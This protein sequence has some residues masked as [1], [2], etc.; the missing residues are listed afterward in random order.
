VNP[1]ST[2][3]LL[4]AATPLLWSRSHLASTRLASLNGPRRTRS[5]NPVLTRAAL[6]ASSGL[7]AAV[8]AGWPL[9]PIIGPAVATGV[10]YLT[11]RPTRARA[12]TPNPLVLAA[13]W[14][15]LS[16]CLRAG[17]PVATAV[18]AVIDH[19]PADVARA[20][21]ATADRLAMGADPVDAWAPALDCPHTAPLARAARHTARSGAALAEVVATL[22]AAVRDGAGDAAEARAQRAAVVIAAPLGLCFLPAFICL[23]IVPVVAGLAGHLSI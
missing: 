12:P 5:L 3:L 11:N 17:L 15:L 10:W 19:L 2:A 6:A 23:G 22:A 7:L 20:L 13:T 18:T 1:F 9:A 14:D 16:A 4:L 8:T 21:R